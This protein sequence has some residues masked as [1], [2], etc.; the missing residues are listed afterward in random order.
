MP[1]PMQIDVLYA[2]P[3]YGPLV[4][5]VRL[6]SAVFDLCSLAF[7]S[8]TLVFNLYSPVFDLCSLAIL[9]CL[10]GL[11]GPTGANLKT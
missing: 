5:L 6:C 1:Y 3:C 9:I 2:R 11:F 10:F 7:N 8:F 4:W